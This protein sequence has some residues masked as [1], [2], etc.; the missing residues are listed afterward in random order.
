MIEDL[1]VM[2]QI[3]L[4]VNANNKIVRASSELDKRADSLVA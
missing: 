1:T 3:N 4:D 2:E